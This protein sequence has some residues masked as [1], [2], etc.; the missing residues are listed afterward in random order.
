MFFY[1]PKE[2]LALP[3]GFA[4]Q[5]L[6]KLGAMGKTERSVMIII[7]LCLLFWVSN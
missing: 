6:K 7:S 2:K 1:K 5:E 3:A 4:K